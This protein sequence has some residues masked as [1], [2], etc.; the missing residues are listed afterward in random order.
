MLSGHGGNVKQICDKH[1]LNPDEII[2]F[3]ASINPLGYPAIVRKAVTEQFND[4]RHYPDSHSSDL[5]KAIA[6]EINC[7]K[8]N[9]I[10]GNGSN[11][12]FYLIPRALKPEKGVLL[13]PTFAEFNDAFRNSNIDV[14]EIINDDR[15]FPVINPDISKL[16]S[17]KDGM[18]FLCNPN[19]PTG[20]LTRRED[21]LELVNDNP[22]R[23][24]VIDEA[25][26]DFVEDDEKYSVIKD[27]PLMDN[28]IVVRSL[29]KFYGFPG[30]R[31]GYLVTNE[32]IVNKL[33][34]YKEPW[35][36]N[37]IAQ[38]AGMAAINDKEF[39]A[40]TRQYVSVEKTFLYDGLT[41]IN[42]IHPFKPTVNFILVRIEDDGI[43]SSAIQNHLLKN[44][45]LIRNCSNFVGLDETY[46]RVAVKTREDN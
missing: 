43:T 3:S 28:L 2:D 13:Q 45:I 42:G 19:N 14:I 33:M 7:N 20:Q 37:T 25:F 16:K 46:F 11:E 31:L 12:L 10:I 5:R 21:I 30:L 22:N 1:G 34:R 38:V 8:S 4:I 15:D 39:T 32:P 44:N 35:T 29:T 24:I 9:I 6:E 26:M 18:V 41:M 40:K 36:V 17:I 23:T 27:A